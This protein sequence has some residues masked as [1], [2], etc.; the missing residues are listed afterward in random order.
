MNVWTAS[1]WYGVR[2]YIL[3]SE[4]DDRGRTHE[5][6][7]RSPNCT[8]LLDDALCRA[9]GPCCNL[10]IVNPT[11]IEDAARSLNGIKH[12]KG[13]LSRDQLGG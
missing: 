5:S 7:Q 4:S 2:Q 11:D 8:Y 13:E 9:I 6:D 1:I 10:S 3:K 12:E